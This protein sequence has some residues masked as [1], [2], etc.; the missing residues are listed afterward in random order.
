MANEA[1]AGLRVTVWRP[2]SSERALA[3]VR[4]GEPELSY[5]D[6]QVGLHQ[7]IYSWQTREDV[8][9]GLVDDALRAGL[10]NRILEG[11]QPYADPS[12]RGFSQLRDFLDALGAAVRSGKSEWSI[13]SQS[14]VDA[15]FVHRI[16]ALLAFYRHLEWVYRVFKD[17]PGVSVS[18]R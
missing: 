16:H 17:V 4:P 14:E 1:T 7:D 9:G 13:S 5:I 10:R 15:R 18:V 3:V 2:Y 6:E 8:W 12:E 11:F